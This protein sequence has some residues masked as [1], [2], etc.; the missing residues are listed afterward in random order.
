MEYRTFTAEEQ[1]TLPAEIT[2][3]GR[4]YE[5]LGWEMTRGVKSVTVDKK[6]IILRLKAFIG[7]PAAHPKIGSVIGHDWPFSELIDRVYYF[8]DGRYE[9]YEGGRKT[10]ITKPKQDHEIF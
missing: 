6:T 2:L 7:D 1:K 5:T 10:T 9:N 3:S 8:K 4:T